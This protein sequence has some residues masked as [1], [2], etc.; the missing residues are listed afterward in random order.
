MCWSSS[1]NEANV[2]TTFP[3]I[4]LLCSVIVVHYVNLYYLTILAPVWLIDSRQHTHNIIVQVSKLNIPTHICIS[5][6]VLKVLLL[7]RL[8]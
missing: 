2:L 5:M 6:D 7:W 1:G 3:T 8:S 4:L